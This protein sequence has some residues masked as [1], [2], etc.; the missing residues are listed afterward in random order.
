MSEV[1]T[2]WTIINCPGKTCSLAFLARRYHHGCAVQSGTVPILASY[3]QNNCWSI[4][5]AA[6]L[7]ISSEYFGIICWAHKLELLL[8]ELIIFTQEAFLPR[9]RLLHCCCCIISKDANSD[10]LTLDLPSLR[11]QSIQLMSPTVQKSCIASAE[12]AKKYDENI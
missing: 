6:S 8:I 5:S 3:Y 10:L 12:G 1:W 7:C 4:V 11:K 9:S 2:V